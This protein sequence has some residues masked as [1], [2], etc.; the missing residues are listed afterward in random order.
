[1]RVIGEHPEHGVFRDA[2]QDGIAVLLPVFGVEGKE[3]KIINGGFENKQFPA[4]PG[5][6][7]AVAGIGAFGIETE[8]FSFR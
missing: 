5:M 6:A 3:G 8:G 2:V 4:F 1:M 7:E